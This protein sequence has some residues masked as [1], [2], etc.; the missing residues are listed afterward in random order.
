MML[1]FMCMVRN[2]CLVIAQVLLFEAVCSDRAEARDKPCL[3]A[4]TEQLYTL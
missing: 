4:Q 2:C 1:A 3:K